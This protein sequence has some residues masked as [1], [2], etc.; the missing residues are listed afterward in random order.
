MP[1]VLVFFLSVVI[2]LSYFC[3]L[4]IVISV[5]LSNKNNYKTK[6][7]FLVVTFCNVLPTVALYYGREINDCVR[8]FVFFV[9]WGH[10]FGVGWCN[11][12]CLGFFLKHAA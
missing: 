3:G 11:I 10:V 1:I 6:M 2:Q 9:Y 12:F 7:F 4:S 5:Y 8:G